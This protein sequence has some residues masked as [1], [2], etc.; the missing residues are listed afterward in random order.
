M[1]AEEEELD[2]GF[3]ETIRIPSINKETL[4]SLATAHVKKVR[5]QCK[6]LHLTV[7]DLRQ[8]NIDLRASNTEL[9]STIVELRQSI[10]QTTKQSTETIDQLQTELLAWNESM[11]EV[12]NQLVSKKSR[13]VPPNPPTVALS[14]MINHDNNTTVSTQQP[15]TTTTALITSKPN[16]KASPPEPFSGEE[17]STGGGLA[18]SGQTIP[19]SEWGRGDKVGCLR[20]YY[21]NIYRAKLVEQCGVVKSRQVYVGL[22]LD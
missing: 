21:V 22:Q 4:I 7:S 1:H 10:E 5:V 13:T 6:Q 15:T 19:E 12:E 2:N 18:S 3:F 17:D 14:A 11:Q 16:I 9:R 20:S 8:S